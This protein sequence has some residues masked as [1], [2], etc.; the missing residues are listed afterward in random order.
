[1]KITALLLIILGSLL[2]AG[3]SLMLLLMSVM[4]FGA[5]GPVDKPEGLLVVF[6]PILVLIVIL[7]FAGKAYRS[8]D[9]SRSVGFGS[10]IGVALVGG[11]VYLG[12]TS[13][14]AMQ[15]F[16]AME[17]Q[18]AEDNRLYPVQKFLRPVE[19][20]TDTIIVFPGRI[21]AYRLYV[22]REFPF[23]GPV[24]D[25]NATRDTIVVSDREFV[26]KVKHEELSRFVDEQGRKL[27]D[28]FAIRW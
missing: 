14:N 6:L 21:V 26:E 4:A 27:T 12:R 22:G 24:G 25:L 10:V 20:G 15:E 18:A 3:L 13:Y 5:P 1:M 2:V 11:A 19:G 17:A 7:F 9:Y 28:V 16:Q 23:A 8:G